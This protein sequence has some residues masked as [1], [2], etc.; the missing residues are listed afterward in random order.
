M[1]LINKERTLEAL[2]RYINEIAD[3]N[4]DILTLKV[5]EVIVLE[6]EEVV[7]ECDLA[8]N[9]ATRR[10][11]MS[12]L[13]ITNERAIERLENIPCECDYELAEAIMKGIIAIN[14]DVPCKPAKGI[15]CPNC[16]ATKR[17]KHP[18]YIGEKRCGECGQLIDWSKED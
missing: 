4:E 15:F 17:A 9:A 18:M 12:A 1:S 7:C 3:S 13:Q 6:Q 8:E 16:Y 11:T 14:K 5:A 10:N 2:R